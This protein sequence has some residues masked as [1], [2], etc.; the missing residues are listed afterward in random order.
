MISKLQG[1]GKSRHIDVMIKMIHDG[2]KKLNT[3]E[4]I[5]VLQTSFVIIAGVGA[6]SD[7]DI[8]SFVK[9]FA[10]DLIPDIQEKYS[11][12]LPQSLTYHQQLTII[13]LLVCQCG[14]F[15]IRPVVQTSIFFY[16]RLI[17]YFRPLLKK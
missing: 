3:D 11:D 13:R 10:K 6:L 16:E 12:I 17:G 15:T 7:T 1:S 4:V 8:F 5:F 2:F 9:Y 14:K